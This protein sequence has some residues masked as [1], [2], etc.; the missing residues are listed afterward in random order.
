MGFCCAGPMRQH[1]SLKADPKTVTPEAG[2]QSRCSGLR[3]QGA[4]SPPP[5]TV[6]H[7]IPCCRY[8]CNS[9]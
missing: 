4:A 2:I 9:I 6:T 3:V 7:I 5:S 1:H 8:L